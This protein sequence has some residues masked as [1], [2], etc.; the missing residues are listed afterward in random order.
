MKKDIIVIGASAGG[1]EVL[2]TLVSELPKDFAASLFVVVHTA[3]SSPGLLVPILERAGSLRATYVKNRQQIQPG[4]IYMPFPDHHLIL[5]HGTVCATR[6]PKENLFRPAVD[7]L[8]RSAAYT[9]RARVIGV[10]LTGGLDDGAE[11]LMVIK[12]LGGTAIVQDPADAEYP[13]MPRSAMSQV[14]VDHSSH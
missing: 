11:G 2:R 13:S 3:K 5:E 1:V 12:Q 4:H 10:A 9:Y 8:F 14:Q 7:P 6:G